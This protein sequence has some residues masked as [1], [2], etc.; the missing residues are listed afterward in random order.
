MTDP[1][2]RTGSSFAGFK[3]ASPTSSRIARSASAKKD[4][5]CELALRR[6][7]SRRRVRY[8]LHYA[9][10]PGRP[11]IVFVKHRVVVF[12]DG[13]F[14]HGRELEARAAKLARGHNAVYWVAKVRQNVE[15]DVRQTR[16]L[17]DAGWLVL[18]FWESDLLRRT[19][20]IADHIVTI[21]GM[22]AMK[23]A[24]ATPARRHR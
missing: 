14:W 12:C 6:E 10:L 20:E 22:Q 18:R 5:R 23:A 8:R 15:R 9:D 1:E 13:D 21:L 7:L 16:A 17:E 24:G 2:K 4:T 11:D 3:P 19:S